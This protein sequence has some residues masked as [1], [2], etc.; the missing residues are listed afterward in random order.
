MTPLLMLA[1]N[2]LSGFR[3]NFLR[4]FRFLLE[5]EHISVIFILYTTYQIVEADNYLPHLEVEVL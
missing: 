4:N 2:S 3:K 1:L 5:K